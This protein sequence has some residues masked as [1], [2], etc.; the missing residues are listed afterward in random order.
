MSKKVFVFLTSNFEEIE[1]LSVVDILRR[2]ELDVRMVSL[3]GEKR[4]TGSHRISVVADCLFEEADKHVDMIVL[5]GGPGTANYKTYSFL[6]ELTKQFHKEQKYIAAICAAPTFLAELGILD[7]KTAVCYPSLENNLHN[8]TRGKNIV[9][10]DGN[11]ITSKGPATSIFFALK[12]VEILKG[13]ELAA[14]IGDQLLA[15]F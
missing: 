4:V 10:V 12:I 5:P 13:K 8:A 15:S 6:I 1:A 7:G 14:T 9:E 11:I 2:A 3:T